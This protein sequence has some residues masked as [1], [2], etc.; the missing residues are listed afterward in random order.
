[1]F[2]YKKWKEHYLQLVSNVFPEVE[3]K[4]NYVR[5]PLEMFNAFHVRF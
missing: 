4:D 5:I 3:E 1:M 2:R